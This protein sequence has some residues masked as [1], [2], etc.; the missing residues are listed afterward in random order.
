MYTTLTIKHVEVWA[1]VASS[2]FASQC[3]GEIYSAIV[4]Q[5]QRCIVQEC[6]EQLP[7]AIGSPLNLVKQHDRGNMVSKQIGK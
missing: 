5:R 7:K 1:N 2:N 3:N 4:T 6:P